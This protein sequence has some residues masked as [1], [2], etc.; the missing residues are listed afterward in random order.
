MPNKT[1][2]TLPLK[3]DDQL[4]EG[5]GGNTI[6]FSER[7]PDSVPESKLNS[8]SSEPTT[9]TPEEGAKEGAEE[10][11][12][13]EDPKKKKKPEDDAGE[14]PSSDGSDA[15]LIDPDPDDELFHS[16]GAGIT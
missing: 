5:R 11:A 8:K 15:D 12:S 13:Q 9:D 4:F 16:K 7:K 14:Q 3:S 10:G 2:S 6:E 1:T